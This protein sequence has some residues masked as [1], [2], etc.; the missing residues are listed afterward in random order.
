[1]T[2][3]QRQDNE[4]VERL[5]SRFRRQVIRKGVLKQVRYNLFHKKKY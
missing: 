4:S 2:Q 3:V 5:L 1:M